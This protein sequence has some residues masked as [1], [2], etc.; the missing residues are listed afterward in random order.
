MKWLITAGPTREPID[1]V[2]FLSNR[3]SG[4]MGYALAEAAAAAGGEV[5]LITG[6]TRLDP[7]EGVKTVPVVTSDEMFEAVHGHLHHVDIALLAAAVCD[8]KPATVASQKLKKQD[9]LPQIEWMPTRDI[10]ASL[11]AIHPRPFFLGGF[12]AETREVAAHARKKLEQK[13][14]DLIM[15]NDVSRTDIGFEGD[16]NELTLFFRDR[17]PL[18]LPRAPKAA[19]AREIVA[20]LTRVREHR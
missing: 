15:A 20:L 1:P 8:F 2:R 10:L 18:H 12:A 5:V 11:G 14:C 13:G 16:E 6:P 19:L 9:G 17:E 3:S 7:P 4:K